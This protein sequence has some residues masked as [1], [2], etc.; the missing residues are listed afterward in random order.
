MYV[1]TTGDVSLAATA[2]SDGFMMEE[3]AVPGNVRMVSEYTL[4]LSWSTSI[5]TAVPGA[6]EREKNNNEHL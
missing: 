2:S 6:N 3:S 5:N 1:V 4:R